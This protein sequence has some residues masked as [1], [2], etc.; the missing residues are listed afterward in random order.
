MLAEELRRRSSY[1][2][3]RYVRH[4]DDIISLP[5]LFQA[6]YAYRSI[7][8]FIMHVTCHSQEHVMQ[9][10]FPELHFPRR[11]IPPEAAVEHS[12]LSLIRPS[13][14]NQHRPSSDIVMYRQNEDIT[15]DQVQDSLP[16][17]HLLP[18]SPQDIQNPTRQVR[19][20]VSNP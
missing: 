14:V 3:T 9:N 15:V 6:K 13:L 20:H 11:D 12:P 18:P 8:Q 17:A 2:L 10:P 19:L 1:T 4:F 16:S 7:A 5:I